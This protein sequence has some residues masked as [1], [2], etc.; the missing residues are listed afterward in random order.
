MVVLGC[1]PQE[2][3]SARR[4]AR[5][6]SLSQLLHAGVMTLIKVEE[7]LKCYHY[8]YQLYQS[9][10]PRGDDPAD[11]DPDDDPPCSRGSNISIASDGDSTGADGEST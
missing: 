7:T 10:F 3:A 6:Y 4:S 11:D 8:E 2:H 1:Q 5:R 9:R